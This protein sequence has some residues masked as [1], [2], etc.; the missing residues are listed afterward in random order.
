M[1]LISMMLGLTSC[2]TARPSS[3]PSFPVPTEQTVNEILELGAGDADLVYW[4]TVHDDIPPGFAEAIIRK[5][6]SHQDVD[7]WMDRLLK[8]WEKLDS[9]ENWSE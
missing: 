9:R 4:A 5:F 3:C 8:L 6:S 7:E 2:T 1:A